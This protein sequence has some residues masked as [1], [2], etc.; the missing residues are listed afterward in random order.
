MGEQIM[1]EYGLSKH[2]LKELKESDIK[3]NIV[4]P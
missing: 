2:Q 1:I 3:S 4:L